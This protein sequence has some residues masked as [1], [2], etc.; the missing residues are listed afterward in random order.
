[1]RKIVSISV[2]AM[3]AALGACSS[4]PTA[5]SPRGE[6]EPCGPSLGVDDAGKQKC[7][8]GCHWNGETCKKDRGV[9]ILQ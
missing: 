6:E 4:N 1:M 9:I 7:P 8:G 2:F 3:L 5:E